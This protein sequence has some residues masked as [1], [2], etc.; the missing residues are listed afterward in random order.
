MISEC[1][2]CNNLDMTHETQ[3]IVK[4]SIHAKNI[5]ITAVKTLSTKDKIYEREW[6]FMREN[7]VMNALNPNKFSVHKH[8]DI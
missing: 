2:T 5:F 6:R 3:H 4:N 1:N 8:L 7:E